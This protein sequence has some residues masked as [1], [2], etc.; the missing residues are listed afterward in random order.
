MARAAERQFDAMMDQSLAVGAR[1]GAYLVHQ[2]DRAFFEESGADPAEHIF[3]RLAF[4]D[5]VVDV[6][7]P[8]QLPQQQSRWARAND[9]YFCPQHYPLPI[10]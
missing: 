9:Y 1:A 6:V 2:R 4:Q 5:D 8:Q 7:A 10:L 3:R